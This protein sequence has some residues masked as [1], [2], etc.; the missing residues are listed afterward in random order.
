M[1]E[2]EWV[3]SVDAWEIKPPRPKVRMWQRE[4]LPERWVPNPNP[5]PT[6][7]T[8]GERYFETYRPAE[9]ATL[10]QIFADTPGTPEG[11]LGF[12]NTYG[13]L[14]LGPDKFGPYEVKP[15]WRS[16]YMDFPLTH[17][18]ELRRAINQFEVH[19]LSAL[20]Q[21][22]D[23]GGVEGGGWGLLRTKLR[24]LPENRIAIVWAPHS[25][26]QFLWLQ[27]A[28]FAA[29][30]AKLFRCEQCGRPF[31]VGSQTGRRSKAKYCSNACRLAAFRERQSEM[32]R[33]NPS[34]ETT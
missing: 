23:R 13:P 5:R 9:I 15:G 24:P 32:L 2:F 22:F 12:V 10:F 1:I 33:N 18:G 17:H 34:E 28:L 26:I 31:L 4:G 14:D 11:M 19:D 30:E 7:S 29:S 27:F 6:L 25:L 3:R 21:G 8:K 16:Y 20:S